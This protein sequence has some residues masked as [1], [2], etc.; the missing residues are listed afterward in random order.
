MST[1]TVAPV[2]LR[3]EGAVAVVTIDNP[4]VNV[5][6]SAVLNSLDE[7]ITQIEADP[8]IKAVVLTGNGKASVAGADIKA[9]P[10]LD[11]VNGEAL[12]RRGQ[13]LFNRLDRLP[14]AVI[15]ALNGVAL[16]G[17]LELALSGDIRIAVEGVKLGLP[18]IGLGIMPGYGGTQRLPRLIGASAAKRLILTGEQLDAAESLRL[19]LVDQVVSAE[20]LLPTAMTLATAI[21]AKGQIAVAT[22]LD[23]IDRGLAMSL[24][25]GLAYEA[26][27]FGRVCATDDK[28]EGISAFLEK[29]A[30]QFQDR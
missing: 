23:T 7:L 11:A 15:V 21:A 8:A 18:E 27:G 9:M 10:A 26:R 24:D 25:D 4:P 5:L 29:R 13:V 17:G 12:A 2:S 3:L 20:D 16:G 19:G 14:K 1:T 6:N 30:P 28:N 22:A